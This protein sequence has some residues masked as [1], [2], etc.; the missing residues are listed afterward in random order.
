M[1]VFVEPAR[2][3]G[4]FKKCN[5]CLISRISKKTYDTK[6][7]KH[8]LYDSLKMQP[9]LRSEKIEAE[10]RQ[11]IT[12]LRSKCVM[13][14][15]TNFMMYEKWL[16]CP[17]NCTIENPCIE[18]Q[19]HNLI[20]NKRKI[21]NPLHLIIGGVFGSFVEQEQISILFAHLMRRSTRQLD[22]LNNPPGDI[23]A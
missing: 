22:E 14:I 20:C 8:N 12:A 3:T 11:I 7:V 10:E 21:S 6:K 9:Y 16:T 1:E 18:T 4:S 5:Q 23:L 17:L 2:K 13:S 19:E 15:K